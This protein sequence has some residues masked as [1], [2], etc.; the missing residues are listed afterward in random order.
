MPNAGSRRKTSIESHA[1]AVVWK[2]KNMPTFLAPWTQP[3]RAFL[4]IAFVFGTPG[5]SGRKT[6]SAER[7][8]LGNTSAKS[9]FPARSFLATEKGLSPDAKEITSFTAG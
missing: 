1:V 5:N 3:H 4:I 8:E 6:S 2:A 9:K 7:G